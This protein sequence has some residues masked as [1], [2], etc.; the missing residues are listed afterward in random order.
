MHNEVTPRH[1]PEPG[2]N[3]IPNPR[4]FDLS[5]ESA[6]GLDTDINKVPR[7][8]SWDNATTTKS[9]EG[10]MKIPKPYYAQPFTS[11]PQ[12]AMRT[13][14]MGALDRPKFAMRRFSESVV[15]DETRAG[16]LP[17]HHYRR[18][19]VAI[20]FRPSNLKL[21]E[22]QVVDCSSGTNDSCLSGSQI[23]VK[24]KERDDKLL[25]G[26]EKD[27]KYPRINEAWKEINKPP[28]PIAE[29]ILKGDIC[30]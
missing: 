10:E 5:H 26:P 27:T 28:S 2:T 17:R 6:G 18:Q 29:A 8:V 19:S 16:V 1:T 25:D 3:Y 21:R 22:M 14:S 20:K 7:T 24:R 13:L 9:F 30:F 12:H 23:D 11:G 4:Y 15:P